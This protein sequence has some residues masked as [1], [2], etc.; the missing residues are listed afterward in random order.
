MLIQKKNIFA[1][2]IFCPQ[3]LSH[4]AFHFTQV[5]APL[6]LLHDDLGKPP[7]HLPMSLVPTSPKSLV[8]SICVSYDEAGHVFH[9]RVLAH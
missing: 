5:D 3:L 1:D 4:M 8:L 6:F 2:I 9:V 7:R